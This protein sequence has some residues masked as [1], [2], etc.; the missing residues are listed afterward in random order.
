MAP[1]R[2]S[3]RAFDLVFLASIVVLTALSAAALRL[4]LTFESGG[5]DIAINTVA[6]LAGAGAAG[7]AWIRYSE[8]NERPAA[9]EASAFVVLLATRG[10]LVLIAVFGLAGPLGLS[11]E[12]P[13]Q[14]P[15]YAWSLAH[16][17]TAILLILA[18]LQVLRPGEDRPA[19]VWLVV[20]LP[21][22]LVIACIALL[23]LIEASLPVM[24]D[25]QGIAALR[26]EPEAQPGMTG[27]GLAIQL[28]VTALYLWGAGLHRRLHRRGGRR[29]AGF[30]SIALVVAA[31][32]QLHW[33]IRPGI[34][35]PIVTAD[36][37]LRAT[38]SI[39]LLMG[40]LAQLRV[41]VGD[42]RRA[43]IRLEELRHVEVQRVALETRA[44]LAREVHDGLAQELWFAKLK[45]SRLQQVDGLPGDARELAGE[46]GAAVDRALGES[47]VALTAIRSGLDGELPLA[48]SLEAYVRDFADRSGLEARFESTPDLRPLN[49][50]AA[51]EVLRVLVEAL[52]NVAKHADAT[53]IRVAV[54]QVDST[55][56]VS[57]ADNGAGFV[58]EAV[59]GTRYGIRGMR[60]RAALIGGQLEVMSTRGA[61]TTVVLR[62]P[63]DDA[64]EAV[65]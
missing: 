64:S 13:R 23:P 46:V 35:G 10:I 36:D 58:V 44:Q 45:S 60:E 14:W 4:D 31:F 37:F 40:I 33:A 9:L 5:L 21:S 32:S 2:P 11:L 3:A 43:N 52:A 61:G 18:A 57:V 59:D 26:G 15:I 24:L 19:R 7:L 12:S 34:Y 22:V 63:L 62:V 6:A 27:A 65:R 53:E 55:L 8:F 48:G 56:E 20:G 1:Q 25:D 42:L 17:L 30:V 51:A 49:P 41:E 29:Y 16:A 54:R 50:R 38:F 39:I 28:V 47:R